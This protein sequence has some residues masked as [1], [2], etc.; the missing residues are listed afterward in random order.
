MKTPALFPLRAEQN[1]RSQ[2]N[3]DGKQ[4]HLGA[5]QACGGRKESNDGMLRYLG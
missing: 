2:S 5:A 3:M 1:V 4:E